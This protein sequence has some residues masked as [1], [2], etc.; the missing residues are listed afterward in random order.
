MR[1]GKCLKCGSTT[2]YSQSN[3]VGGRNGVAVSIGLTLDSTEVISF[4]C[5]TCGYFEN[6][7]TAQKKLSEVKQKWQ[8][9]P[10]EQRPT[11]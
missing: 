7:F 8:K 5:A 3:G 11:K 9:V 4:V 10:V 2:I 6:Y 1:N